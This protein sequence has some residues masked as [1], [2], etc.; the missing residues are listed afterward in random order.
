MK[1]IRHNYRSFWQAPRKAGVDQHDRSVTFLELFYDLVYVAVIA[2]LS[3]R[4]AYDMSLNGIINFIFLFILVWWAWFNGAIYHDLHGNNDYRTRI[5]TFLQMLTI[6]SMAIYSED[7]IGHN[8]NKFAISYAVFQFIFIILWWRTGVHDRD[9]RPI[10]HSYSFVF[11]TNTLLFI[12]SIFV[13]PPYKYLFWV[14]ALITALAL[15]VYLKILAR[16]NQKLKTQVN[17]I[18]SVSPSLIE[19]FGLFTIIV[20]GEV[21]IGVVNSASKS[22]VDIHLALPII[23]GTLIAIGLWRVYFDFISHRRPRNGVKH[24]MLWYY[25][26]LPLTIGITVIGATMLHIVAYTNEPLPHTM[27]VLFSAGTATF[28]ICSAILIPIIVHTDR[29]RG[30]YKT[31]KTTLFVSAALEIILGFLNINT[32][33]L[34]SLTVVLLSLP[35]VLATHRWWIE[36]N[37]KREKLKQSNKDYYHNKH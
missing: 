20:L 11:L 7:A 13:A 3:H 26:H 30:Y 28:M 27:Q 4:L 35:F 31:A 36:T 9:H 34:L 16:K 29:S 21:I 5:F 25:M 37:A 10:A 24:F 8:S 14:T 18:T 15:P 32:L 19:R 2:Q 22:E 12:A 6:V 1:L 23:I 33:M 17:Y